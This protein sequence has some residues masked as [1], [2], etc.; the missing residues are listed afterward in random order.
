MSNGIEKLI[1]GIKE[2]GDGGIIFIIPK[3]TGYNQPRQFF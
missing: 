2:W 1:N 3:T